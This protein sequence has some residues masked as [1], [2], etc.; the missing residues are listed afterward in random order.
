MALAFLVVFALLFAAGEM[1][2]QRPRK[3]AAEPT[4]SLFAAVLVLAGFQIA[5]G[6]R[7]LVLA[8]SVGTAAPLPAA[9]GGAIGSG[10]AL[11]AGW[12]MPELLNRPELRIA[13][14]IA[15]GVLGVIGLIVAARAII[16]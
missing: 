11:G 12:L 10:V 15:G 13:R 4:Q 16:A 1:L 7:F 2:L 3:A 8:L 6:A 14:R 5:D 9:I